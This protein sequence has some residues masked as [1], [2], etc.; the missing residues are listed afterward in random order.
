MS[1]TYWSLYLTNSASHSLIYYSLRYRGL[2]SF[3]TSP[4]DPK[5]NLPLDYARY[6]KIESWKYERLHCL[7][8][9]TCVCLFVFW[10]LKRSRYSVGSWFV[11]GKWWFFTTGRSFKKVYFFCTSKC[12]IL[13]FFRS[14]IFQF[15]NFNRTKKKILKEDDEESDSALVR[16]IF[17]FLSFVF[18]LLCC[19]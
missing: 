18:H 5:E 1:T 19:V 9:A 12:L 7:K 15:Q 6:V 16:F 17:D 4:W 3:R 13:C 11:A 14:R 10:S 8:G 2:K